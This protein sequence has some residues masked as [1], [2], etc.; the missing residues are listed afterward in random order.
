MSDSRFAEMIAKIAHE[1]RSPLTSVK[2][3]SSTL[4]SKWDRFT[5]DQKLE[6]VT[7][8]HSDA[9]RMGRIVSEVLDLARIESG[10]LELH[11]TTVDLHELV[12]DAL[13]H[14]GGRAGAER[15][16]IE[17]PEGT[18][19]FIDRERMLHVLA[20]L[21][22]NAIKFS[23]AG[24]IIVKGGH[25]GDVAVL[26]VV[27][28]GVGIPPDRIESIFL[29]PAPKDQKA[30]PIGTGLGLYLSR[31]LAEIHGGTLTATSREGSGSTLRLR[32]P[33]HPSE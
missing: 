23:D 2:G 28:E 22:E 20:N 21:I 8:I 31:K 9:E 13:E 26:E 5:D 15:V 6:L 19:L 10:L 12:A 16:N 3:F 4:V 1:L 7:T 17:V 33:V 11:R 32:L 30:T 18:E 27:D 14:Q 24:P 29:G 25:D